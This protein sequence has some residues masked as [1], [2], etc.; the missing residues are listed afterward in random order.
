MAG[1]RNRGAGIKICVSWHCIPKDFFSHLSLRSGRA[2]VAL[3]PVTPH[4]RRESLTVC[5]SVGHMGVPGWNRR[6][7]VMSAFSY[8]AKETRSLT[9]IYDGDSQ[10]R[11]DELLIAK[12]IHKGASLFHVNRAEWTEKSNIGFLQ[13]HWRFTG[14]LGSSHLFVIS[15][16]IHFVNT[17][18]KQVSRREGLVHVPFSKKLCSCGPREQ[19]MMFSPVGQC[20][21]KH[22]RLGS[23]SGGYRVRI[24]FLTSTT[25][26]INHLI[27]QFFVKSELV[28]QQP[29]LTML[30]N[31]LLELLNW[32]PVASG[33][34]ERYWSL[35]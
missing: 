5:L 35:K 7:L 30:S 28:K 21:W 9:I 16:A 19:G 20:T 6:A 15:H 34:G 12:K 18:V 11:E 24:S 13:L 2:V 1:M 32:A 29:V 3:V 14:A 26:C 33:S 31:H 8:K 27:C 23:T 10:W 22:A 25:D 17:C 4:L